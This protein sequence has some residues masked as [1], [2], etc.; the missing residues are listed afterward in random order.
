[1]LARIVVQ[2]V[3]RRQEGPAEGVPAEEQ[4]VRPQEE[5]EQ[6]IWPSNKQRR[7]HPV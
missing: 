7:W 2:L 5:A 4:E 1:M 6:Y 3:E